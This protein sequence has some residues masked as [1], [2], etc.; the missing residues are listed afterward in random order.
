MAEEYDAK[1]RAEGSLRREAVLRARAER[2]LAEQDRQVRWGLLGGTLACALF[3]LSLLA[4]GQIAGGAVALTAA[5]GLAS[6]LRR[7]V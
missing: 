7:P 2:R 4:V 1:G 6:H 3:G 5:T